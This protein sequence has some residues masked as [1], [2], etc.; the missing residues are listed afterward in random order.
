MVILLF[1]ASFQTLSFESYCAVPN[2]RVGTYTIIKL[3]GKICEKYFLI[4][5]FVIQQEVRIAP[6][7][8]SDAL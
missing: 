5:E 2:K 7:N 8:R 4:G 1:Q 6:P 3:Q